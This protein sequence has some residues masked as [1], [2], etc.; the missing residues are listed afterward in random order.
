MTNLKCKTEIPGFSIEQGFETFMVNGHDV[1]PFGYVMHQNLMELH[2]MGLQ[3]GDVAAFL[4]SFA[5][6]QLA[7][8]VSA[9]GYDEQLAEMRAIFDSQFE[10]AFAMR[11]D[12]FARAISESGEAN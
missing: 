12:I 7:F 10:Q 8:H 5:A 6:Y 2:R 9:T 11:L 4:V 3:A 1:R